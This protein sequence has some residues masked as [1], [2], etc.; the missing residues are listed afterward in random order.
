MLCRGSAVPSAGLCFLP[1][2][3]PLAAEPCR[4]AGA[5]S[6]APASLSS[7]P[8]MNCRGELPKPV[9]FGLDQLFFSL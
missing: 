8:V 4:R 2:A 3:L 5:F 9:W 7:A 1:R 6:F